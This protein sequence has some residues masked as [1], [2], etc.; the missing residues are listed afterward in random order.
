LGILVLTIIQWQIVYIPVL[1]FCIVCI[2]NG[3]GR[4]SAYVHYVMSLD[5]DRANR[6]ELDDL[7]L[8]FLYTIALFTCRLSGLAF[9]TR[10][11]Q[12]HDHLFRAIKICAGIFVAVFIVQFFLLLFHCVPVT[13]IWPYSWQPDYHKYRCRTWGGV[14]ITN[15]ALSFG[16]DGIMFVIPSML[17]HLLHVPLKRKMGL[18]MVMF[19]GVL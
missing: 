4:R 5:N 8:H 9:Y 13:G 15:S 11:S 14:Y 10:L 17:I 12:A 3:T 2:D 6:S 16:C 18:A 1:A 19:P 7:V